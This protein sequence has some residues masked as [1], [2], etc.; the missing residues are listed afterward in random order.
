MGG[1]ALLGIF[2]GQSTDRT[3]DRWDG[4]GR[5][6]SSKVFIIFFLFLVFAATGWLSMLSSVALI[7]LG[8]PAPSFY[9]WELPTPQASTDSLSFGESR[10]MGVLWGT[11]P[12]SPVCIRPAE[13]LGLSLT[14]RVGCWGDVHCCPDRGQRPLGEASICSP[15]SHSALQWTSRNWGKEER[16]GML[17]PELL[18][19]NHGQAQ[20]CMGGEAPFTFSTAILP[21]S[22]PTASVGATKETLQ[23]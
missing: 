7:V 21:W 14:A 10:V 4:V 22:V 20:G 23:V 6:N 13:S 18:S 12:W 3:A 9:S 1:K 8:V 15:A 5:K 19:Q 17:P 16:G 11:F 2:T